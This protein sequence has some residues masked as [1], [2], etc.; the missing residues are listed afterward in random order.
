MDY[1]HSGS[2]G[3]DDRD[4]VCREV[5]WAPDG[6]LLHDSSLF[7]MQTQDHHGSGV[8][9]DWSWPSLVASVPI[10]LSFFVSSSITPPISPD[11]SNRRGA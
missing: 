8:C 11:R 3:R 1:I 9:E 2:G 5:I 7:W 4:Y 10:S 6:M